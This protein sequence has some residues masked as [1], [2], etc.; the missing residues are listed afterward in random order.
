MQLAFPGVI[1]VLV[2]RVHPGPDEP[3]LNDSVSLA[4]GPQRLI[5][6]F[7]RL[8]RDPRVIVPGIPIEALHAGCP[9]EYVGPREIGGSKIF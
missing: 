1:R 8:Q 9:V 6:I 4:R 7:H 5:V 2:A 3:F